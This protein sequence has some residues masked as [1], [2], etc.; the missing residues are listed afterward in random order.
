MTHASDHAPAPSVFE[1]PSAPRV[2]F[3]SHTGGRSGAPRV[4]FHLASWLRERQPDARLGFLFATPGPLVEE[5]RS[6]GAVAQLRALKGKVLVRARGAQT[7][8][9]VSDLRRQLGGV[10]LVWNNTLV[11]GRLLPAIGRGVGRAPIITHVHE[12]GLGVNLYTEPEALAQTLQHSHGYVAASAAV[13]DFLHCEHA[14]DRDRIR[15]AHEFIDVAATR[16][17]ARQPL[18][19]PELEALVAHPGPV[20]L[21]CAVLEWRKAP[22]IFLQVAHVLAARHPGLD[23]RFCWVGGPERERRKLEFDIDR[24]GLRPVVKMI[25]ERTNP[26]PY[27][28]RADVLLMPS[29]EDCYPLAMLE[30]AALRTP[31]IAFAGSGGTP[32]FL[33]D[34]AGETVPYLD[35]T[36]MADRLAEV[37]RDQER[38]AA[39]GARAAER[40]EATADRD[41]GAERAWSQGLELLG[42]RPGP[43]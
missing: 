22:E 2:L 38:R 27:L 12:L 43:D 11:N 13:G 20:V 42:S 33:V 5:F 28:E 24:M 39:L 3:I 34:G 4:I 17:A 15:V 41:V 7:F 36:A 37:L 32:E 30:A 19:D 26:A 14:V 40:V 9:M 1:D 25:G 23:A 18:D 6:L 21:A 10:D 16:A 8:A 29:R 31:T 35:V